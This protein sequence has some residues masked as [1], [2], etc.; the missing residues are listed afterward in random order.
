MT[1]AARERMR[2]RVPLL[3][4]AAAAWLALALQSGAAAHGPTHTARWTPASLAAHAVLMFAAMM[5]P[6]SGAPVRHVRDRSFASR[7]ARA[8]G[9]FLAAYA[10]PWIAATAVLLLA[11][12]WIVAA[13]DAVVPAL[14]VAGVAVCQASPL[15]QRFLNRCHGHPAL[16]A[17]GVRA[18][19]DVLRFGLSHAGWCIG[20]CLA[21]MLLPMLVAR[22]HFA[23][24]AIMA[25]VTL[26]LAGERLEKPMPPRWRWRGPG[27]VVRIAAGRARTWRERY[28]K[29]LVPRPSTLHAGSIAESGTGL[30]RG[31]QAQPVFS[32]RFR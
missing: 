3:A 12:A 29:R 8:V 4:A 16:A 24:F 27:K 9:L 14:A 20:S 2:V 30:T 21:L 17:F 19:L 32:R 25:G 23:H 22:D 5:L 1:A 11:A 18:D 26:W 6:L 7:R 13:R 10:L 15:K 31:Q 28:G